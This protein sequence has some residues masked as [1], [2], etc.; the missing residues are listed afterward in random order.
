VCHHRC[1]GILDDGLAFVVKYGQ[2]STGPTPYK[3]MLA[4]LY[5]VVL[6]QVVH[7]VVPYDALK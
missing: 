2:P 7:H 6:K 5:H 3:S 1:G 4:I